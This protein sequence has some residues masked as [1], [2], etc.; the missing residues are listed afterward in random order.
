MT[1]EDLNRTVESELMAEKQKEDR[2]KKERKRQ[3][4]NYYYLKSLGVCTR[5]G[6][7]DAFPGHIYCPSCM[8]KNQKKS[9]DYYHQLSAEDKELMLKK[10]RKRKK[11]R[12]QQRK[13]DGLCVS[14]GKKAVKGVFC[15]ECYIK[16]KKGNQKRAKKKKIAMGG[17]PRELRTEKGL[18][19]FCEEPALP[20]HR[21][22]EKHYSR[23]L[24]RARHA[25]QF[26]RHWRKDNRHVFVKKRS[27]SVATA[28]GTK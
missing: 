22:C 26:N 15:L 1:N 19:R 14:C 9:R 18:C 28:I 16:N 27:H 4:D 8:E 20:G 21:L 11:D 13:A 5:C 2:K 10:A 3:L 24:E 12:Y 17:D 25:R 23:A 7:E 6:R